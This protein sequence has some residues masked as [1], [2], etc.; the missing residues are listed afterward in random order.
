MGIQDFIRWLVPREDHFFRLLEQQ[1]EAA[2]RGAKLAQD[3]ADGKPVETV[4]EVVQKVENEGDAI[5][6]KLEEALSATFVTPIDRED[7]QLLSS[8]LDTVLDMTNLAVR[9]AQLYGVPTPTPPMKA[10]IGILVRATEEVQR[11]VACVGRSDWDAIADLA[12]KVRAMEKEA[13]V[14]FR[15]ALSDLF[16]DETIDPRRILRE[17][18]VLEGLENAVDRCQDVAHT[19]VN[20]AVKHG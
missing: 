9:A 3:F 10:L 16:H 18:E 13:D 6:R 2:V 14:V 5:V 12:R 17:K 4:S 7:I 11:A 20:F 15:S 8:E 19:L 1:A